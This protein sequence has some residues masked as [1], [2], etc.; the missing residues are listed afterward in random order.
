MENK[1]TSELI[2]EYSRISKEYTSLEENIKNLMISLQS[3]KDKELGKKS[4][5]DIE[6]HHASMNELY[7]KQHVLLQ[8]FIQV[9]FLR[10]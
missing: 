6:R 1:R 7:D 5:N 4:I 3:E 10:S 9:Y 8:A 2:E